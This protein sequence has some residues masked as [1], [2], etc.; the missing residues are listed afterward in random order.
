[1]IKVGDKVIIYEDPITKT[2]PEEV[3][4]IVKITQS[5]PITS[6]LTEYHCQVIFEIEPKGKYSRIIYD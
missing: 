1:M 2:K 3:A 6:K 4:E 5:I